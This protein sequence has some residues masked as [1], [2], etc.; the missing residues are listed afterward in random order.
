MTGPLIVAIAV[1][2]FARHQLRIDEDEAAELAAALVARGYST[3]RNPA[4]TA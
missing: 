4:A 1:L 3:D 2:A